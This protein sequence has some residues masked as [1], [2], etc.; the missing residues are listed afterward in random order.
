M[1]FCGAS[2]G[3][4]E[5]NIRLCETQKHKKAAAFSQKYVLTIS[6]YSRSRALPTAFFFFSFHE[7]AVIVIEGGGNC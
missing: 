6:Y 1:G 4:H 3:H 5:G 7:S 2:E